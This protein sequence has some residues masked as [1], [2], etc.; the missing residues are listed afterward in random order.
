MYVYV[1]C[2]HLVCEY[3]EPQDNK[4]EKKQTGREG[5]LIVDRE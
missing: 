5:S 2:G 4:L 3:K 1:G